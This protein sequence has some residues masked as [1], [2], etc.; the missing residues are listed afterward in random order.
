MAF[1]DVLARAVGSTREVHPR[2]SMSLTN[3]A[4]VPALTWA[5]PTLDRLEDQALVPMFGQ[6]PFELG[7]AG[8]EN[9]LIV[10][11]GAVGR[12]PELF[13]AAFPEA[14]GLLTIANIARALAAFERT[15]V[16]FDAPYDRALRGESAAMSASALRGEA[17]FSSERFQCF[18]CHVP[19]FFTS[20]VDHE[21]LAAPDVRFFNNGLY[22]IDGTGGYPPSNEGVSA[23][24]G[25]ASDLGLFRAPT[26]RNLVVTAPYMHDGSVETL[27]H[28]LDHYAAGGRTIESGPFRGI[29][30]QHPNKSRFVNGFEATPAKRDDLIAFLEALT[31]STFLT[32]PGFADPWLRGVGQE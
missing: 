11:P 19:P 28:V 29:G 27:E 4:Y 7:L 26:L 31:D 14:S 16:S 3:V 30:R 12:Y 25:R 15:L 8:L 20:A 5:N 10:R 6:N 1:A 2:G 18:R 24:I 13:R 23:H 32:D 9:E 17:L 21:G 22:N